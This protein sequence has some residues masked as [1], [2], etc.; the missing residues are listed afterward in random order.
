[1]NGMDPEPKRTLPGEAAND[2]G[3]G[4]AR[5]RNLL[6]LALGSSPGPGDWIEPEISSLRDAIPGYTLL[7]R[8]GRGATGVVYRAARASGASAEEE[9]D[10]AIKIFPVRPERALEFEA[11]FHREAKAML[12]LQHPN[13]VRILGSGQSAGGLCYLVME[14]LEG[15]D[16]RRR[17][18]N[19]PVE[20]GAAVEMG[21]QICA[22][23]QYAHEQGYVHRDIKPANILL[24]AGGVAKLGD[25]GLAKLI[26]P[27]DA[28]SET[29]HLALTETGMTLGTPGYMAPEQ[30]TGG[31]VDHRADLYSLGVTLYE[32]LTGTVPRGLFTPP[33]ARA[34]VDRKLDA[35]VLQA[36]NEAPE[37]RYASADGMAADLRRISTGLRGPSPADR[38]AGWRRPAWMAA[39]LFLAAGLG[40][41]GRASPPRAREPL[42]ENEL[43][44]RFVP[45][46]IVGGPTDGRRILFSI[47]ETRVRDYRRFAEA[48]HRELPSTLRS[49]SDD[50]PM[51][52][53]TW[54]EADAFCAWLTTK[55]RGTRRIGPK[56]TY[57]LPSDHEWSCAAGIGAGEDPEAVPGSKLATFD[58]YFWGR[59]YPPTE[60]VGNYRGEDSDL[61]AY[62]KPPH[63]PGYR[64]GFASTAP[65]GSFPPSPPGLFD[66]GGNVW[67]ICSDAKDPAR[68]GQKVLRG[69]SW[70]DATR[71]RLKISSRGALVPVKGPNNMEE[72]FGTVG[73]RVILEIG[74]PTFWRE[75]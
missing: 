50:H 16:L 9:A 15:G 73:F 26:D 4:T 5:A 30:L 64:D 13:L 46:P 60:P 17:L 59:Q 1:M 71:E 57:R 54:E 44:M 70:N 40:L 29:E 6:A 10:V 41:M 31:A 33:S 61:V 42:F 47:W 52:L 23:L 7:E 27:A 66:L 28:V 45:V 55:E 49:P 65:V 11:R 32:M 69:A 74:P 8:I 62:P 51:T 22:G 43:G 37:R 24:T 56:D 68:P 48:C 20:A 25:F 34:A 63:I 18:Q 35:I 38:R 19:G 39:A 53:V 3:S 14:Y 75:R 21:L 36:L 12:R 2:P 58:L 67:E 72:R